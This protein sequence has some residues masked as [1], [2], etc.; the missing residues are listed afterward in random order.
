MLIH[1]IE[2]VV[3]VSGNIKNGNAHEQ[4]YW[5]ST[6]AYLYEKDW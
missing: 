3:N 2:T 4:I 6:V 5:N 1:N